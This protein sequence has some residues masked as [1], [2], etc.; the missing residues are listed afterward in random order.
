MTG[1][2]LRRELAGLDVSRETSERLDRYESLVRRWSPA[3]NLVSKASLADF[4]TRH[5]ADSAQLLLHAPPGARRW[6]DLGSGGGLPGLVVAILAA[7][8]RPDLQVTL[9]EADARKAAFLD[10]A[11][12]E[13]GLGAAVVVGRAETLPPLAADVI[14]ARALAP[15][16]TLLGFAE[17]HMA[18]G[19]TALFPKGA[20]HAAEIAEAL[21][22]WRFS[23]QK[24]PSL[25]DPEAVILRIGDVSRA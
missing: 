5:L 22:R 10:T 19:G 17:R 3:I 16:S 18:A 9:V 8:L 24:L 11:V 6:A 21:D 7:E 20:R 14:S 25:T 23:V 4:G 1:Q 12:R 13:L 15:L 2:A